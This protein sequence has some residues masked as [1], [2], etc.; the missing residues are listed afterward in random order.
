MCTSERR[1]YWQSA[2]EP[3][4]EKRGHIG[5]YDVGST[6]AAVGCIFHA[7]IEMSEMDCLALARNIKTKPALAPRGHVGPKPFLVSVILFGL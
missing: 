1:S 3:I 7:D 5:L 4:H 2:A 6:I